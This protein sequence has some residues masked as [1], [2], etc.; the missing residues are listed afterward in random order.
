MEMRFEEALPLARE[1]R[2]IAREG[3]RGQKVWLTMRQIRVRGDERPFLYMKTAEGNQVPWGAIQE[4]LL[5][6][7]WV[8][9]DAS[10]YVDEVLIRAN[11]KVA[12]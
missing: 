7:D 11:Q 5:A 4:D 3:W 8:I 10:V 9:A 1:G 6:D 12:A 2:R